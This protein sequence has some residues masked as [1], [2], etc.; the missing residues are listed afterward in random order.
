MRTNNASASRKSFPVT[1][2]CLLFHFRLS[3]RMETW[4]RRP[5]SARHGSHA[6]AKV[7]ICAPCARGPD[8]SPRG[9]SARLIR[10]WRMVIQPRA[11]AHLTRQGRPAVAT[12]PGSCRLPFPHWP[13]FHKLPQPSSN[14]RRYIGGI[15]I[16]FTCGHPPP[17]SI[18]HH[19]PQPKRG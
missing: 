19:E 8:R 17:S 7:R 1:R 13:V 10:E 11:F 2:L 6:S 16:T 15:S 3:L 18:F 9:H 4:P 5:A 12:C 14:I